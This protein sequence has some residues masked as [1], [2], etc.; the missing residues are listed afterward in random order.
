[1]ITGSS[2]AFVDIVTSVKYNYNTLGY[3]IKFKHMIVLN[4]IVI[5]K[6]NTIIFVSLVNVVMYLNL[7]EKSNIMHV[8]LRNC[9]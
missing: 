1:V 6:E 8:Y 3:L 4:L 2:V 9:T 5:E 7:I